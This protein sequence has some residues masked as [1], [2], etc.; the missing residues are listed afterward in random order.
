MAYI[1]GEMQPFVVALAEVFSDPNP[2]DETAESEICTLE[3]QAWDAL[4]ELAR[5]DA[6][7]R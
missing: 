1:R 4:Q 5:I 6:Q 7:L 3:Q 2:G